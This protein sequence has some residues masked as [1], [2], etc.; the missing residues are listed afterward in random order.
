M[1]LLKRL[2]SGSYIRSTVI[3]SIDTIVALMASF[4]VVLLA[5]SLNLPG[6]GTPKFF[7]IWMLAA[8]IGT[9]SA[10]FLTKPYQNII[11]HSTLRELSAICEASFAKTLI[12][13]AAA[14]I[15]LLPDM[16]HKIFWILPAADLLLTLSGLIVV[17]VLMI[18]CY[19]ILTASNKINLEDDDEGSGKRKKVLVYGIGA[20]AAATNTRL[21]N[22]QHYEII[23]FITRPTPSKPSS[24]LGKPIY[25][26]DSI[27][28]L[29]AIKNKNNFH[30]ILF[31]YPNDAKKEEEGLVSFARLLNLKLYI[32]PSIDEIRSGTKLLSGIRDI[33]IEDLLGRD[34]IEIRMEEVK[35]DL[36]GKVVMVTGA[37]GSIG[38]ELC[39]QLATIGVE[40]LILVDNAET[41]LHN[42]RLEFED[43]FKWVDFIP[44]IGDVRVE[45]RM[46]YIFREFKPQIVF[47]AAA[48]KHVPLMEENPCEAVIAN[49]RGSRIVADK[50]VEY[51]IEKMVMISTDKAVNPTNV[52]GCT[53]RLA[54]IYVQSLGL[55]IQKGDVDGN[56]RFITTRFGNVL[57]SNG[58]VIP[59]F[60]EQIAAGG[61]LTVTH[62]EI[63]RFFM[64]IPEACRLV[65]EAAILGH[66]TR[67][68][69]FDMGTPVKIADLAERMIHLAGYEVDKD[70][71]IV[72]SGLRPGEKL[73]EEVLADKENTIPTTHHRIF[74]A[75]VREYSFTEVREGINELDSLAMKAEIDNVV[76]LMKKL[77]PE[78]IS[79]HSRFSKFDKR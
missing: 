30:G 17:R 4:L 37:A 25:T 41:P 23:G 46:D 12:I 8:L 77:V 26:F 60:K 58:S 5:G 44:V 43:K 28:E 19:D 53:K 33:K 48:Y 75:K 63:R 34:E 57:G 36:E 2:T 14:A 27:D 66:E 67:I 24:L 6:S 73:Y 7:Y 71:K 51:G 1:T 38:S 39:R 11:R 78:F 55:A 10:F 56:T 32:T 18:L 68:Y 13:I 16:T 62:P 29:I 74:Q 45:S 59:R 9:L 40:K 15:W 49:V 54:E 50:C 70:I 76:I 65:M 52:M 69:A 47:H 79:Q 61:P 3:L 21:L 35:E 22:S 20:K 64:T 42:I 31:A 72:F